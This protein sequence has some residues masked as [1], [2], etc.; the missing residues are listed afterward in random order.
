MG[1]L[2]KEAGSGGDGGGGTGGR[3]SALAVLFMGSTCIRI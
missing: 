2:G 1:W 3:P